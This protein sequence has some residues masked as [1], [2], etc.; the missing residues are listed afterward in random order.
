MTTKPAKQLTSS[1]KDGEVYWTTQTFATALSMHWR[2]V[3]DDL[4]AS[5]L[6]MKKRGRAETYPA[7]RGVNLLV[8]RKPGVSDADGLSPSDQR[9]VAQAKKLDMEREILERQW[10]R[11]E[12]MLEVWGAFLDQ[13]QRAIESSAMEPEKKT[14]LIET[15]Q[16]IDITDTK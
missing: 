13:V 15:L 9:N 16:A 14:A 4:R 8:K 5:D 3:A 7:V 11:I 6:P 2:K 1:V 12:D 10:I